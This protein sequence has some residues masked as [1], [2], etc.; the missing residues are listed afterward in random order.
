[1]QKTHKKRAS[2]KSR[3]FQIEQLFAMSYSTL[4]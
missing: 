2:R 1:M 3:V 4:L